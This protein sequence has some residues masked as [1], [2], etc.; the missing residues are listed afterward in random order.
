MVAYSAAN[1]AVSKE[2][3]SVVATAVKTAVKTA[4]R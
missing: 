4:A 2:R 3:Q 1:S